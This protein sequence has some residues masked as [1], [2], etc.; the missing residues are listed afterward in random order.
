MHY[1]F[2]FQ[3]INWDVLINSDTSLHLVSAKEDSFSL[4]GLLM[5]LHDAK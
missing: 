2:F 3:N 1:T 5:L 4:E